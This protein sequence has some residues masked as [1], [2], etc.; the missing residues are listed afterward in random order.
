MGVEIGLVL[1]EHLVEE[2]RRE[3]GM[4]LVVVQE[5]S[6]LSRV[7]ERGSYDISTDPIRKS[8][9]DLG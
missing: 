9:Y 4:I 2:Y 8:C 5:Q 1:R 7:I 6:C 3:I